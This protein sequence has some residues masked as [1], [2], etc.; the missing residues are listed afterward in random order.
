M[1]Y[2][3]ICATIIA[4]CCLFLTSCDKEDDL[5]SS[6]EIGIKE[7]FLPGPGISGKEKEIYEKYNLWVRM[8]FEDPSEVE[9]AMLYKDT[10]NRGNVTK[11]DDEYRASAYKYIETLLSD[12]P[13]GFVKRFFPIDFFIVKEYGMWWAPTNAKSLGRSRLILQWPNTYDDNRGRKVL[14]VNLEDYDYHYYQDVVLASVVWNVLAGINSLLLESSEEI[15]AAGWAY[16]EEATN[17]I[18]KEY[19]RGSQ[20][21]QDA[22]EELAREG[23]FI[24]ATGSKSFA[25]DIKEWIEVLVLNSYEEVKAEYLDDSPTRT[26]KYAEVIKYF[27][28]LGWDIQATGNKY[29]QLRDEHKLP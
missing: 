25:N 3:I 2:K 13:E 12:I 11:I 8:D 20:E 6:E 26:K 29:A 22:L 24:S 16:G 17:K 9:N 19:E 10:Y 23:G 5:V 14:D 21:K 28:D 18:E 27:N 15:E 4:G 1:K 7:N